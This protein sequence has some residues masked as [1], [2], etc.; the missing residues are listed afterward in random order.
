MAQRIEIDPGDRVTD[1]GGGRSRFR[2]LSALFVFSFASNFD[3]HVRE[4]SRAEHRISNDAL[5][6]EPE[7]EL[8]T[9]HRE[10]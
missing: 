4:P 8:S 9:E 6:T 7:H 10:V 2:V 1:H 3:V 5:C